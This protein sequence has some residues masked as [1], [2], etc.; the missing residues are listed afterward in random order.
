M[1]FNGILEGLFF[2]W[3]LTWFGVEVHIIH[4]LKELFDITITIH[5][6]YFVFAILGAIFC[7]GF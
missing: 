6:Y 5:G 3:V 7:S 4:A 2:A 1:I